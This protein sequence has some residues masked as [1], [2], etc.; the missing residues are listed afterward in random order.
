MA[1]FDFLLFFGHGIVS[2]GVFVCSNDLTTVEW[3]HTDVGGGG[4]FVL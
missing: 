4:L 2:G 3:F 1:D